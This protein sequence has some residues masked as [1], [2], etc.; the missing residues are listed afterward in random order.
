MRGFGWW[1]WRITGLYTW[2]GRAPRHR[3]RPRHPAW[4]TFLATAIPATPLGHPPSTPAA[5]L[6]PAVAVAVGIS[7]TEYYLNVA[8]RGGLSAYSAT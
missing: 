5:H 7:Y 6:G 1:G 2:A 3:A 8:S 4:N